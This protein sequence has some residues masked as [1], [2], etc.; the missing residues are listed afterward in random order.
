M[1]S[2]IMRQIVISWAPCTTVH[3]GRSPCG[4][5]SSW[6]M[7]PICMHRNNSSHLIYTRREL[8]CGSCPEA[9]VLP[10]EPLGGSTCSLPLQL[11][12]STARLSPNRPL[13]LLIAADPRG[14]QCISPTKLLPPS[15]DFLHC[16]SFHP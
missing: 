13:H 3:L 8:V 12:P 9:C 10:A 7:S 15:E 16:L 14:L 2:Q 4:D 5:T 1:G 6:L 11:R